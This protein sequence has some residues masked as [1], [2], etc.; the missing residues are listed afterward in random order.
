[1]NFF[2]NRFQQLGLIDYNGGL[3]VHGSLLDIVTARLTFLSWKNLRAD[4]AH[5]NTSGIHES[6]Q[7]QTAEAHSGPGFQEVL[8]SGFSQLLLKK[9]SLLSRNNCSIM[10]RSGSLASARSAGS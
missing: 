1:M 7:V 10:N 6:V 8:P 2:M 3:E 4:C 9:P 5:L